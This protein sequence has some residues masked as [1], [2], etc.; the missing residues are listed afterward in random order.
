[1]VCVWPVKNYLLLIRYMQFFYRFICDTCTKKM[2]LTPPKKKKKKKKLFSNLLKCSKL[3]IAL[4]HKWFISQVF[5]AWFYTPQLC[6][7]CSIYHTNKLQPECDRK[8]SSTRYMEA[9]WSS[10]SSDIT[11]RSVIGEQHSNHS[12]FVLL[13]TMYL[14]LLYPVYIMYMYTVSQVGNFR[15]VSGEIEQCY[16]FEGVV[17]HIQT[18]RESKLPAIWD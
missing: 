2:E 3:F 15:S 1:M 10:H 17:M 8:S 13:H 4:F 14:I 16:C 6:S 18:N 9:D 5:I 12:P 11:G 7:G